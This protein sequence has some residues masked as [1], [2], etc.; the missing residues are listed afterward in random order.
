MTFSNIKIAQKFNKTFI[1]LLDFDKYLY[2]YVHIMKIKQAKEYFELDVLTGFDAIKDPVNDGNWL[3]VIA[4]KNGRSWT[5]QTSLGETKSYA[6]LDTLVSDIEAIS[7]Q[8][9]A[10]HVSL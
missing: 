7:G 5:A 1:L 3:L 8:V 2:Q 4:G 9:G 6:R 10:L